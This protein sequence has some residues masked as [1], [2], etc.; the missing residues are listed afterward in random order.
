MEKRERNIVI[1]NVPASTEKEEED[2][3]KDDLRKTKEILK[4]PLL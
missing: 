3:Q 4:E 2:R 1:F